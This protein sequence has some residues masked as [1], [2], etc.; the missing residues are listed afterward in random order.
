MGVSSRAP[1]FRLNSKSWMSSVRWKSWSSPS[2]SQ[3]PCVAPR[4]LLLAHTLEVRHDTFA[5]GSQGRKDA[6]A[7]YSNRFKS[8]DTPPVQIA[9]KRLHRQS[10]RY[11]AFIPLNHER[12]IAQIFA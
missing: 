2:T 3:L 12:E 10:A 11:I 9:I 8:G 7:F 1:V 6:S 5:D 4:L